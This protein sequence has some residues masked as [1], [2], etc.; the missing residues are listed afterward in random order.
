MVL[1]QLFHISVSKY[2]LKL[3]IY[4]FKRMHPLVQ[5]NY[6][7]KNFWPKNLQN[8]FWFNLVKVVSRKYSALL[9]CL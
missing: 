8:P 1:R 7:L 3:F 4:F 6:I 2:F 9:S 5:S